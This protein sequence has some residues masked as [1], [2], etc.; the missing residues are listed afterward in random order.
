MVQNGGE[1]ECAISQLKQEP[2]SSYEVIERDIPEPGHLD[3]KVEI[4][5][6]EKSFKNSPQHNSEQVENEIAVQEENAKTTLFKETHE[7]QSYKNYQYD[8]EALDGKISLNESKKDRNVYA[9]MDQGDK[10]K[11]LNE[12]KNNGEVEINE[13]NHGF[14]GK[15]SRSSREAGVLVQLDNEEK[16]IGFCGFCK[17]NNGSKETKNQNCNI[18]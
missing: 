17:P 13:L 11:E 15:Q 3:H 10:D 16:S 18:F 7:V 8:S 6:E 2:Q 14:T 9:K 4:S 5:R 12:E 1:N